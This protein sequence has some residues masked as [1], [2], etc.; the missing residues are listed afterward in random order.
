[1]FSSSLP[2]MLSR[3][4][5]SSAVLCML[6]E[7]TSYTV[8]HRMQTSHECTGAICNARSTSISLEMVVS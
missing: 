3:I 7:R 4:R 8:W 1:L 6:E 5:G 2:D